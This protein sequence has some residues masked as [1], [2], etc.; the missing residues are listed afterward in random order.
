MSSSNILRGAPR[1]HGELLKLGIEVAQATVA[2][3]MVRHRKPP[4]QTWRTFLE[5]HLKDLVP[6]DFIIVMSD[7]QPDRSFPAQCQTVSHWALMCR[8]TPRRSITDSLFDLVGQVS[9]N[10]GI[11]LVASPSLGYTECRPDGLFGMDTVQERTRRQRNR[12]RL[13]DLPLCSRVEMLIR[14]C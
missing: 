5:N 7:A 2:K 14:T 4:S 8:G 10:P 1:L 9:G 11:P 6:V 12:S 13:S 3:H